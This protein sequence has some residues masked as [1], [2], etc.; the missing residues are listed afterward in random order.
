MMIRGLPV[1]IRNRYFVL[2]DLVLTALSA[3]LGFTIRLGVPLFWSQYLP[4]FAVYLVLAVAIKIP[5]YYFFGLYR[6][7]WRYASVQE[8]LSI[9]AATTLSSAILSVLV[10]L[11][12]VPLGWF[13]RFPRSALV[14]DWLWSLFFIG[15]TRFSLR[16]LGE[17]SSLRN[18]NGRATG[19]SRQNQRVLVMG[20]GDAG[21]MIVREMQANPGMGFVP[22]GLLDDNPAKRGMTI[23]G[24]PVQGNRDDIPRLV[25]QQRIDQVL[26]AMPAAPGR[27]IREVV[28]ICQQAG[29]PFKTMPG[30]Y[31]L[32]SGQVS[33]KQVREVRIEDL[34]RRTPVQMD[35]SNAQRFLSDAVVLITGA[36]GSIGSEL[37][38]QVARHRPRELLL[39]GH[40][41]NSV[42]QIRLELAERFPALPLRPLIADVRDGHRL[43]EV[44]TECQPDVIF[45]TAAHKHVPLMEANVA[46]AV[47]NNIFG[48]LTLLQA[49]E[50]ADVEHFVLVS[51]DKAVNPRCIMGATKRVAEILVQDSARRTGHAYVVV[52]FGNVLGSRGSVVPL[53]QQQIATRG[54]ITVTHP[55]MERYFMT[56]PEAVQLIIQAAVMG[57]GGELFVLDMGQPVRIVDLAT[58]LIRL[59]GMEPGRDITIAFTGLR[60]GEKLSE[61]LFG[62]G[63]EPRSTQ[64]PKIL[65]ARGNH[66]GEHASLFEQLE[67][68]KERTQDGEVA[69][70]LAKIQEIVPEYEHEPT[71]QQKDMEI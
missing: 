60:P 44:L 25:R 13:D 43:A 48:T 47:S 63:E 1:V 37:C 61:E 71:Q 15:G 52:R 27:S 2:S 8:M 50:A 59:S 42:H 16:F 38:R 5:T 49:A 56:I 57:Q 36:G 7:Y 51:T 35:S 20:A 3:M 65:V 32:I 30:I 68:L 11:V 39:L 14:I 66:S 70:L 26:I 24:V 6:R 9:V 54:T 55:E 67:E 19:G 18:D 29:V 40:G 41:E 34:L 12:F 53:F 45:H 10:L 62:E 58:E 4:V 23:H 17:F 64:H 28:A 46:E 31:E 22:V 33:V 21:A 69:S